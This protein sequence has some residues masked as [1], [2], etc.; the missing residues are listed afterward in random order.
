M[1]RKKIAL[2]LSKL[3]MAYY[4]I[5][6]AGKVVFGK[7]VIVNHKFK[8]KG[9]G[10]VHIGDGSNLWAHAE[11]N[12][13]HFYEKGSVINVG[14]NSRLNG[15]TFH[16]AKSIDI[17]KDCLVGSAILMDTDFHI[18]EDPE[19]V[20]F[21]NVKSKPIKIGNK[22]WLGGQSVILKGCQLGDKS[23]IGFRAIVTKSFPGNVV[24]AGNPARVVK[25]N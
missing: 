7:G 20:L 24:V 5:R 22:V 17:G 12:S 8:V 10:K 6:Y 18:F 16:C 23:V 25:R 19:H 1:S 15:V 3:F 14:A 4:K 21:G 13:F 11:A 9:H 2:A